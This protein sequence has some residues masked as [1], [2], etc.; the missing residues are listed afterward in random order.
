MLEQLDNWLAERRVLLVFA[1]MK[2]PVRAKVERY[3]LGRALDSERFHPTLDD[4]VTRFIEVTGAAWQ[5]PHQ[6]RATE[7]R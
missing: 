4:A 7:G 5:T 3:E 2:D 1:E 6:N